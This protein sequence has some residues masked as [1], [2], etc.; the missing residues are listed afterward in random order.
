MPR[1]IA[2][3]EL[4]RMSEVALWDLAKWHVAE[5]SW[6]RIDSVSQHEK[7]LTQLS[8]V[9]LELQKRESQLSLPFELQPGSS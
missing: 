5:L 2:G 7:F 3:F 1:P 4:D 6:Y 8:E 9:L